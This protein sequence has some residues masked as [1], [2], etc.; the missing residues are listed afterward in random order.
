MTVV[1][2]SAVALILGA[3]LAGGLLLLAT[4]LPRWSAPSLS[5]RIAPY[6]RDIADPRGLTPLSGEGLAD[7]WR[8]VQDVWS[9]R[10]GGQSEVM[11]RLVRAG[12]AHS[13][14]RYRAQQL[15]WTITG[16]ALGTV[17]AVALVLAGRGAP[18]L[19]VLP[20]VGGAIGFVSR[21]WVLKD[22]AGRRAA[23]I[24]EELPAVLEFLALC[25]SAGESLRDALRRVSEVGGGELCLMLREVVLASGTGSNLADALRAEG[26]RAGVPRLSRAIEHIT[27]AIDRG[28]PLAHVLHDLA[29][30]ARE[31]A[32]RELIES[33]G[34]KEV[35]MLL[36]LVFLI[37]PLS[38]LFAVYPGIVMLRLGF[39]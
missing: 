3:I 7:R 38:V 32:K 8:R 36:P 10:L 30:D 29:G 18:P 14:A 27:A 24:G 5:R 16:A 37:L 4:V 33:A 39:E 12:S 1:A 13:V 34:R 35:W 28:A 6:L 11:T 20:L 31:E 26:D 23:R 17:A 9:A 15:A 22:A 25:L 21:E 19:F 2:Q